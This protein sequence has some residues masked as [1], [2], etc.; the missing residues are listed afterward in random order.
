MVLLELQV[1]N[2]YISHKI[3]PNV[4]LHSYDFLFFLGPG[5]A[6]GAAGAPGAPGAPGAA[7]R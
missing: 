6:P 4:Y 2:I 1:I 7:G 5:G 3:E